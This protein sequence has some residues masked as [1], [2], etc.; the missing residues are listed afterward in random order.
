[1]RETGVAWMGLSR[2]LHEKARGSN[3]LVPTINQCVLFKPFSVNGSD[4]SGTKRCDI[5][6]FISHS[7]TAMKR[8]LVMGVAVEP[9][10]EFD[11]PK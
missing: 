8:C 9:L 1:M 2:R 3:P 11:R 10:P 4:N 6:C 5:D 7:A